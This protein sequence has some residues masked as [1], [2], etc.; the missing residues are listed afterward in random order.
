MTFLCI[1]MVVNMLSY[2]WQMRV[3]LSLAGHLHCR[4]DNWD[5][6]IIRRTTFLRQK[7]N[8]QTLS[9][10]IHVLYVTRVDWSG[11]T[12]ASKI[13]F[14]ILGRTSAT[15]YKLFNPTTC[16]SPY[17]IAPNTLV[18][19]TLPHII[20]TQNLPLLIILT[21]SSPSTYNLNPPYPMPL[22]HLI[23]YTPI[24]KKI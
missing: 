3:F 2:E 5:P 4:R 1:E 9:V 20:Q 12:R 11:K 15:H 18:H 23:P 8:S 6:E 10:L 14:L 21:A 19:P 7:K 16:M 24:L 22:M 17:M 13:N